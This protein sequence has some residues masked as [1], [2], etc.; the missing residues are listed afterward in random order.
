MTLQETNLSD[1]GISNYAIGASLSICSNTL[2]AA[3]Q[4]IYRSKSHVS[5]RLNEKEEEEKLEK[6]IADQDVYLSAKQKYRSVLHFY[7]RTKEWS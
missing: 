7:Y 6:R 5:R 4:L 1:R 2:W 3:F